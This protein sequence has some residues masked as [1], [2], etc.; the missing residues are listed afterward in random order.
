MIKT[1]IRNFWNWFRWQPKISK[2]LPKLAKRTSQQEPEQI[3]NTSNNIS[4]LVTIISAKNIPNRAKETFEN[5]LP[6][7]EVQPFIRIDYKNVSV[8]TETCTGTNPFWNEV[9]EIPLEY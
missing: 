6:E 9:L 5:D 8:R 4:I 1:L 2:P 3:V 7:N